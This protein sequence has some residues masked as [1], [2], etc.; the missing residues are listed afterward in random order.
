MIKILIASVVAALLAMTFMEKQVA[1][2]GELKNLPE[3][4]QQ[5]LNAII[6]K[7]EEARKDA[8][9]DVNI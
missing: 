1:L 4:T 6:Q 5:Q 7:N 3:E 8:L 2:K 9:K